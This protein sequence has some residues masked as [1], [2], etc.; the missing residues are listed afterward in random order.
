MLHA[1]CLIPLGNKSEQ[2]LCCDL[3]LFI[4]FSAIISKLIYNIT[5][6]ICTLFF[7]SSIAVLFFQMQLTVIV[8]ALNRK[9]DI[10]LIFILVIRVGN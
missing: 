8:L 6:E 2:L 10:S 1:T 4:F 7:L 3:R 5:V 9:F